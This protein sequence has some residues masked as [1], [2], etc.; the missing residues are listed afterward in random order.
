MKRSEKKLAAQVENAIIDDNTPFN[1]TEA[2]KAA[3]TN[4][5]FIMGGNRKES[6]GNI[7]VFTGANP[8]EGKTTVCVNMALT[9]AQ[10]GMKV[11][12]IDADM[13]KPRLHR[14][15]GI[16]PV[17][18]LSDRLSGMCDE[19]CVYEI[20]CGNMFI[21]PSGTIPPNPAELLASKCME[22]IL[23]EAGREF[24]YVFVDMPPVGVVTDA[25]VLC[26]KVAGAVMVVSYNRT[27]TDEINAAKAA[28][29][30]AGGKVIGAVLNSVDTDRDRRYGRYH[31]YGDYR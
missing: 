5:M 22:E 6:N 20:S 12:V 3:R 30:A 28:I 31:E 14:I 1:I 7:V 8:S 11:L 29:T 25:A 27:T 19:S 23:A 10:A 21:L 24:D 9:F 13:R 26:G 16:A 17:P 2:Y 18:G 15:F 4:L